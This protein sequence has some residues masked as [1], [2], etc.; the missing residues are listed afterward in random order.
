MV[1]YSSWISIEEVDAESLFDAI[2]E[3]AQQATE[4]RSGACFAALNA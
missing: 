4:W 3:L 1:T 2:Q